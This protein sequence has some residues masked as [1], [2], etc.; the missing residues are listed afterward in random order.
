M[1]SIYRRVLQK[2][3]RHIHELFYKH[4]SAESRRRD[5]INLLKN[6]KYVYSF[7]N[8]FSAYKDLLQ[9]FIICDAN[10]KVNYKQ[11]I[12]RKHFFYR[13]FLY[14]FAVVFHEFSNEKNNDQ[15]Q[16]RKQNKIKLICKINN[17]LIVSAELISESKKNCS[18]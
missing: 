10:K 11:S 8:A 13:S 16:C 6:S 17:Y 1:N 3:Y 9:R 7:N 18:S 2:V 14:V 15:N 4:C 12:R 5:W